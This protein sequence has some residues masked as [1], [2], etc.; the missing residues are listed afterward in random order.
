M[1]IVVLEDYLGVEVVAFHT[2]ESIFSVSKEP[3]PTV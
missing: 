1:A 2:M 3:A